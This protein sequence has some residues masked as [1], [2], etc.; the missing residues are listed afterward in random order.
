[1]KTDELPLAPGRF[2]NLSYSGE[3][4]SVGG[5]M[6]WPGQQLDSYRLSVNGVSITGD[7]APLAH[8]GVGQR[9]P[10]FQ[11]AR[12]SGF[13]L[14]A[15]VTEPTLRDWTAIDV[16]GRVRGK[17]L[18]RLSVLYRLG[19]QE[20][21]PDTPVELRRRVSGGP[22]S[23]TAIAAYWL[24]GLETFS[25]FYIPIQKYLRPGPHA[26]LLDWGCGCGRVTSFFLKF[27]DVAEIHGCDIDRETI[28]WCSQNLEG[29]RFAAIAPQPPTAYGEGFF[30]VV[31]S[32]SVLTHLSGRLQNEWLG[33]M[34]RILA[35]G[36]LL[37]VSVNGEFLL[38]A[39]DNPPRVREHFQAAGISDQTV[40]R[41]LQGIAPD[42]YY[43]ATYQR[44]EYT[45]REFSRYF[46][47]LEY[48]ELGMG[49]LQDLVIMRKE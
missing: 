23:R 31:A 29:G 36:G 41:I 18:C 15:L 30:D 39:N 38:Q 4:L 21:L 25:Q 28:E 6:F 47:I 48:I 2:G 8:P 10:S 1:M 43:R 22:A 20:A 44:K 17:D 3:L 49:N 40:D 19:Y 5:W 42:G 24:A 7:E 35:P 16:R 11:E 14:R 9:F 34:K 12:M 26:R 13:V 27:L 46:K 37:L 33:E 45:C 32:C